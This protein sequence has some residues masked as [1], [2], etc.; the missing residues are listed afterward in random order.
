M[1]AAYPNSQFWGFD[2]HT[3]SI[4]AARRHA[5]QQGLAAQVRFEVGHALEYP[6]A[7]FDLICFFDCLHDMGDP[8]GAAK[9]A[10]EALAPDGT[11]M[12]VEP[13]ANDRVEDNL[14]TVGRL[15]YAAST[16]ICCAHSLSEDVGLALGAQAG[17][18]RWAG[19]FQEA[20]FN[21]LRRAAQ[22]PFNLILEA[23]I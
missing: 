3:G 20:G 21:R 15:F 16:T 13:Y 9:Y 2:N 11:V 22:T 7:G 12:L 14:N 6:K 1:A 17:E 18:A 10:A 5:E 23:R 19:I 8:L 4:E